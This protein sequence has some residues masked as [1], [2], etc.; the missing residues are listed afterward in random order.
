MAKSRHRISNRGRQV[1]AAFAALGVIV[2]A[3]AIAP[4][5]EASGQTRAGWAGYVVS[6]GAKGFDTAS[7][8]FFIPK[9]DCSNPNAQF[10]MWLG[11]GGF[12][13]SQLKQSGVAGDCRGPNGTATY[14]AFKEAPKN[15]TS[16]SKEH[17]QPIPG[18]PALF[19]GQRVAIRICPTSSRPDAAGNYTCGQNFL[20][21]LK[22]T[23]TYFIDF[24]YWDTAGI[25]HHVPSTISGDRNRAFM[26][27]IVERPL[28]ASNG[29]SFPLANFGRAH[30]SGCGGYSN[31][32]A[33]GLSDTKAASR[34]TKLDMV[35]RGKTLATTSAA[36]PL[37]SFDVTWKAA[38]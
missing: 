30:M 35:Y 6:G 34:V 5:A 22:P 32:A 20:S 4:S 14:G 33:V 24:M 11:L 13:G 25:E 1:A 8:G 12:D 17:S 26:E 23:T 28:L 18:V 10:S 37:S 2:L 21:K 29:A 15:N 3:F 38:S 7:V 19:G 36:D 16:G 31:G 9:I 27:C